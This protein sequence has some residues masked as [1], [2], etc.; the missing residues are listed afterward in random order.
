MS[1]DNMP[2][3]MQIIGPMYFDHLTM[4]LAEELEFAFGGWQPPLFKI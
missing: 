3:G 2:I 1:Q 4:R